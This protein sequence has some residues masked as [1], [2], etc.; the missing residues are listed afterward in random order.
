MVIDMGNTFVYSNEET[1]AF[2]ESLAY[3][4]HAGISNGSALDVMAEDEERIPYKKRLKAMADEANNGTA[5]SE[6]FKKTGYFEGYMSDMVEVG[7]KTGR[8]EEALTAISD[9]CTKRASLDR[10]IK[11]SLV[12]PSILLIVMLAVI[13]VLLI[14]VLPIFD[15][16]YAQLGSGLSGV[17]GGFLAFGKV[18]SK[19][20]PVLVCIFV[21]AVVFL[22][23]FS[24]VKPFR[25]K[26][27]N[28]LWKKNGSGGVAG[29]VITARFA[30]GMSMCL[31]SGLEVEDAIKVAAKMSD[32]EEGPE[33]ADK[34]ITMLN[35]GHTLPEALKEADLLGA[36]QCRILEAGIK[37]GM[38][39]IAMKAISTKLTVDSE[40]ALADSISSI[41]PV[42][43]VISSVLVGIIL[44]SVMIPLM[45]IMAAIG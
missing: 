45:N 38:E 28:I 33:K 1:A 36:T 20:T 44:I 12:Y 5:L 29:K 39:D 17:A 11:S 41:E 7:E 14:V 6:I 30:Q 18:L 23:A 22:I 16:V 40:L 42:M 34:C 19:F 43:T 4:L 32:S 10:Q 24:M 8:V 31:S 25:D 37:S 15:E 21:A 26:V 35:T 27:L 9:T 13:A 3:M 2:C